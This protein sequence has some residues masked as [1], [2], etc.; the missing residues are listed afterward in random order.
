[1]HLWL[2]F[3]CPLAPGAQ[4]RQGTLSLEPRLPGRP[5]PPP[6]LGDYK[7]WGRLG[8]LEVQISNFG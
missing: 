4:G 1:M 5:P 3:T 6:A 2:K 8:R 7:K